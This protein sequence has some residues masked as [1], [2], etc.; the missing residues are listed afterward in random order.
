MAYER[1]LAAAD[2]VTKEEVEHALLQK[3]EFEKKSATEIESTV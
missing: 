2:V 1:K 3:F